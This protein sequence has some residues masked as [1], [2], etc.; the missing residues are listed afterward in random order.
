[1]RRHRRWQRGERPPW[2]PESETWP[3]GP[4]SGEVWRRMRGRFV[5]RMV[6]FGAAF[7]VIGVGGA[8]LLFWLLASAVGAPF[9]GGALTG[10]AVLLAVL[11]AALLWRV[12]RAL[13]SAAAQIGD[14]IE[15]AARIESGDYA[16]RVTERGPRE[17]R[18]L[19]RG[20]DAMSRQLEATDTERR[21]LL[22][23][24]SHELR[25]PLTVLQG[26]LE[27]ML[28]GVHPA[29]RTHLAPILEETRVLSRLIDDLRTLSMA[30]AGALTLHRERTDIGALM[31]DVAALFGPQAADA[32]IALAVD[33]DGEIHADVDPERIREV[34]SNLLANALRY[35]PR[36]GRV[37]LSGRLDGERLAV[38][39]TDSGP[40]IAPDALPR[41]FDRFYR[42]GDSPGSGLG[43]AIA[44]SLIAA[45]GGEIGA[46]STVGRGTTIRFTLPSA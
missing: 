25:T 9:G 17:L 13:R 21:R 45:H 8:T 14:L 3:P 11:L 44:R 33:V 38:E 20:F 24:V 35:T 36:G 31:Q 43:L 32:G 41:V 5:W 29:D 30:E 27:A 4:E 46:R 19:A 18:A 22:A 40:G 12:G 7:V 26:S 16:V 34:L 42:S 6:A 15:A 39:L 28:D 2:W 37:G 10:A 23:D 1:M